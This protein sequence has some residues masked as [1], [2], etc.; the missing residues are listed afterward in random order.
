MMTQNPQLIVE[1]LKGH[2]QQQSTGKSTRVCRHFVRGRCTWGAACRFSHEADRAAEVD[3]LG[4]VPSP[5]GVSSPTFPNPMGGGVQSLPNG[6]TSQ[7]AWIGA[8]QA[9]LQQQRNAILRAAMDGQFAVR[10]IVGPDGQTHH[11]IHLTTLPSPEIAIQLLNDVQL[12]QQLQQL[13]MDDRI[14]ESGLHYLIGEPSVFWSM[15]RHWHQ[16][17][18]TNSQKW[19]AMLTRAR[20]TQQVDCMFYRSAAGC[21]SPNC[22]FEH[23][24]KGNTSQA[25]M[26]MA[27]SNALLQRMPS[28]GFGSSE[29]LDS[30]IHTQPHHQPTSHVQAHV[31]PPSVSS[32]HLHPVGTIPM[33]PKSM[34]ASAMFQSSPTLD[35]LAAAANGGENWNGGYHGKPHQEESLSKAIWNMLSVPE[36]QP[37]A[38][39]TAPSSSSIW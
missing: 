36:P 21:L 33:V 10:P 37:V 19:D 31:Q 9:Q 3:M 8:Q 35:E 1:A 34:S 26:S 24:P 39:T 20:Q 2:Q 12:R 11:T 22:P 7:Q 25:V 15:I 28:L 32:Q 27:T 16:G 38:V 30:S 13:E 6:V 18:T 29:R 23:T 4:T 14:R 17:G 5:K